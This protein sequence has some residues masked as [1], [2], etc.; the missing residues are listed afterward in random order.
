M[1]PVSCE[2]EAGLAGLALSPLVAKAPL[3]ASPPRKQ[4]PS[5][6]EIVLLNRL[7]ARRM[8]YLSPQTKATSD[9]HKDNMV[10][11]G[12]CRPRQHIDDIPGVV[13]DQLGPNSGIKTKVVYSNETCLYIITQ[14]LAL[15]QSMS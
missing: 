6:G 8:R 14:M 2:G 1:V 12:D 15:L 5:R 4:S 3:I 11:K 10:I 7:R 9:K 13:G